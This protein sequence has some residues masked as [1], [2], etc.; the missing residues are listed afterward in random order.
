[1]TE[2]RL[3]LDVEKHLYCLDGKQV[4]SVT[5]ILQQAGLVD[6][7]WFT[8][9]A[10]DRG[11][12]VHL[13]TEYDDNDE[14]DYLNL[15]DRLKPYIDAYRKFKLE[16]DWESAEVERQV[17]DE[18]MGYAGTLDRAGRIRG[19]TAIIDVKTGAL[20]RVVGLQLTGYAQARQ[21]MTSSCVERLI[22]L[23]LK[24]NGTYVMKN[25]P[26]DFAAW[27]AAVVL[28]SWMQGR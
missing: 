6:T 19:S 18:V 11:S 1:M 25:Y 13:A 27:N 5:Q 26:L 14:L 22:G 24:D 4:R 12:A 20:D 28:S 7:A 9:F 2:E 16:T 8:E 10:R 15:D 3:T 17:F 21:T 23:R